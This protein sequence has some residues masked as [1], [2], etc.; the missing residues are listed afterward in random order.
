MRGLH[1]KVYVK[2]IR[3]HVPCIASYVLKNMPL[4]FV[5][6]VAVG[7]FGAGPLRDAAMILT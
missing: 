3:I 5:G 4:I 1:H 2:C 7:V 6:N